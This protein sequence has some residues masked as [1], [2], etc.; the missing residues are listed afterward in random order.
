MSFGWGIIS[1][2]LHPENKIAPASNATSGANLVADYSRDKEQAHSF[3][4]KHGAL[5]AYASM[6]EIEVRILGNILEN[7]MMFPE[8]DLIPTHMGHF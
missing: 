7:E 4:E 1:T 3:A 8:I 5:A 6:D 2:G